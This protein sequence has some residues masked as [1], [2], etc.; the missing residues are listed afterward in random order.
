MV[1]IATAAAVVTLKK[2]PNAR[3]LPRMLTSPVEI[4]EKLAL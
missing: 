3:K 2:V 1:V 4:V